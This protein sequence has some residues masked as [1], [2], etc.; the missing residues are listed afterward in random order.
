M[1]DLDGVLNRDGKWYEG[2][3][4]ERRLAQR[5]GRLVASLDAQIVVS[6]DWRHWYGREDLQMLLQYFGDINPQRVLG[7]THVPREQG[8][9]IRGQEI[10]RWLQD[11]AQPVRLAIL[12]DNHKG[13]FS[14]NVVREWFVK[15]DP[16]KGVSRANIV[17]ATALL[18]DGPVWS[19]VQ[20]SAA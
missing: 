20:S 1:L 2:I 5:V 16:R 12:D 14:M 6:S 11:Y 19:A 3:A 13:R 15:T 4:I 9:G 17:Q 18:T 10:Q 7:T 8:E